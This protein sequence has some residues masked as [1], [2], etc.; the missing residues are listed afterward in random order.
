M[1]TLLSLKKF[2]INAEH[3]LVLSKCSKDQIMRS[4]EHRLV[5]SKCSKDQIM[6]STEPFVLFAA[7]SP[8]TL[9][10]K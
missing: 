5:L 6:R 8:F 1:G 2:G 7:I 4:T 9:E 3:R 10:R